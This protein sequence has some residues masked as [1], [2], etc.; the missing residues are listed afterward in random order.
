M[1]TTSPPR[2]KVMT[3]SWFTRLPAGFKRIGISRG[4]PR[5]QPGGFKL[6]K[7]LAPG[8]WFNSVGPLEYDRLYRGEILGALQPAKVMDQLQEM[9]GADIPVLL[10]FETAGS[11][12]WCHR[13]M[14]AR[15]LAEHLGEPV[16]EFGHETIPQDRHPLFPKEL[17]PA[18]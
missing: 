3:A 17:L 1:S 7:P 2:F 4:T 10:C 11:G 12:Q 16:P 9:A 18:A 6:F 5:G 8:P 15:W 14:A 13:A